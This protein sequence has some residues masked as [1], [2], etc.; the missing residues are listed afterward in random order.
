MSNDK[1]TILKTMAGKPSIKHTVVQAQWPPVTAYVRNGG[2]A[3]NE[4]LEVSIAIHN[5]KGDF[6]HNSHARTMLVI[7]ANTRS[8]V[9]SMKQLL[10]SMT[11]QVI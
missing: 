8:A 9:S 7:M 6:H 10:S 1:H 4:S 11:R 3:V 2:I 5:V